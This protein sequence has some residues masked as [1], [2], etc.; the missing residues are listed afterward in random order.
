MITFHLDGWYIA[1]LVAQ[2][3]L[4][5]LVALVTTKVSK[6]SDKFLLLTGLTLVLTGLTGA[7]D[8]HDKGQPYDL[9]KGLVDAAGAFLVTIA[10]HFGLDKIGL[11]N[12]ATNDYGRTVSEDPEPEPS[13]DAPLAD[14]IDINRPATD[15]ASS[16]TA[17]AV[18]P[19]EMLRLFA[20]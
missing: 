9:G 16:G 2:V 7:L 5:F 12:K 3:G 15:Q 17:P 6:P 4:P 11:L 20:R 13:P 10:A 18:P 1:Q 19:A 14:V 8:A